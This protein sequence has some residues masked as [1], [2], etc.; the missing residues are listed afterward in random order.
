MRIV[1]SKEF[2]LRE[3]RAT[4]DPDRR[5]VSFGI[6]FVLF[7]IV[8]NVGLADGRAACFWRSPVTESLAHP[9]RDDHR[10]AVGRL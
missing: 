4:A 9:S 6:S 1:P 2:G 10:R 5:A 8:R 3:L 7:D